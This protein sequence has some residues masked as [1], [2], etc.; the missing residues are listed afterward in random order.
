MGIKLS[1]IET[2]DKQSFIKCKYVAKDGSV[3]TKKYSH[4]SLSECKRNFK[5]YIDS[6]G[7][8]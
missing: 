1:E 5:I 4:S 2:A 8:A 7:L 6:N 3:I